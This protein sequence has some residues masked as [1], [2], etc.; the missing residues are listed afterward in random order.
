MWCPWKQLK[1]LMFIFTQIVHID[2][3]CIHLRNQGVTVKWVLPLLNADVHCLRHGS[4]GFFAEARTSGC[5]DVA[6]CQRL[7]LRNSEVPVASWAWTCIGDPSML[8]EQQ[9]PPKVQR[10]PL[11]ASYNYCTFGLLRTPHLSNPLESW[12]RS[13]GNWGPRETRETK[14]SWNGPAGKLR[15]G[16]GWPMRHTSG[17]SPWT[18]R[19]DPCDPS[20]TEMVPPCSQRT[21]AGPP[22][23]RRWSCRQ[24]WWWSS[25]WRRKSSHRPRAIYTQPTPWVGADLGGLRQVSCSSSH[26]GWGLIV[27]RWCQSHS[28]YTPSNLLVHSW[29]IYFITPNKIK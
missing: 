25:K 14:M 4:R 3:C 12:V 21:E 18:K 1:A 9:S 23:R 29:M 6:F 10:L 17:L 20:R 26:S 15:W 28:L 8:R 24:K 16:K 2:T 19:S 5:N 27:F 13:W 11:V 7:I 22:F